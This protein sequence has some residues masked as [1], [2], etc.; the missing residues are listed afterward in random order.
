MENELSNFLILQIINI[1]IVFCRVGSAIMFIP[2]LGESYIPI[3]VKVFFAIVLSVVISSS[4]GVLIGELNSI[5]TLV[6]LIFFEITIGLWIGLVSRLIMLSL[7]IAG[8]IGGQVS[9]LANAFAPSVGAF[10]GA[11]VLST[12]LL[13]GGVV[14]VFVSDIHH[15]MIGSFINSYVIFP[16][17]E[18]YLG[19]M[20]EQFIKSVSMMMYIGFSIA[21]PFIIIGI[22]MNVGLGLAN[23]MMPTL[24]VFFVASSVLI[25][26]GI[27]LMSVIAPNALNKFRIV[28]SDW[29][30][31]YGF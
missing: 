31:G 1:F 15:L 21:A 22:I 12:F 11:T 27:F 5:I 16:L 2:G 8:V 3:R 9:A 24:P 23:R 6:S 7:Q 17:G 25:S 13:L 19:D 30:L 29:L 10:E 14:V 26:V 28:L 4:T 20:A 18:I